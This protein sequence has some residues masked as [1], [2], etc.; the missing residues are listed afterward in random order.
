MNSE[1]VPVL[2]PGY[3]LPPQH[4]PPHILDAAN[5]ANQQQQQN[6]LRVRDFIDMF[7]Q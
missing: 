4:I 5:A 1:G 3:T 7:Y 2:A 6:W